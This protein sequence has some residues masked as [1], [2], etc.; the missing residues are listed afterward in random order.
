MTAATRPLMRESGPLFPSRAT[1]PMA[2]NELIKR[3][4]IVCVNASGQAVEGVDGEGFNAVGTAASTFDNRT[5]APEGG[6]AGAID[7]EIDVGVKDLAFTGTTPVQGDVVYVVDNQTVSTDSDSGARGIAGMVTEVRGTKA[8]VWMGSHV[9]GMIAIAATE[10]SQLD[11][12]QADILE[13]QIHATSAEH[14][15]PI[16]ITAF[17]DSGSPQVEFN[18]GVANGLALVDS[19]MVA[20]RFNPVGE[21]TSLLCATIP[22]PQDLDDSEDIVVHLMG[23]RIGSA[24]TTAVLA[25]GAFF[26]TVGAAH[27]A[28]ADAGGNT[29]ALDEAT[30]FV[31][32]KTVTI[33]AADVPAAPCQLT[34]TIAPDAALDADDYCLSTVWLEY[35]PQYLT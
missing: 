9:V 13:L 5:T 26:Q 25:V 29:A 31:A 24:D 17:T 35:T 32:E 2:A 28:D 30:T 10:A 23:C 19:E 1:L 8:Y 21:D 12:A 16:P 3:G 34:L 15:I 22:L 4:W 11:T 6:G 33:D 27:T 14:C 20:H 18:D 7:A